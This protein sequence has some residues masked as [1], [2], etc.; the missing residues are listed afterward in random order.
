MGQKIMTEVVEDTLNPIFY[1]ARDFN[2]D[3]HDVASAPPIV[4]SFF[5]ANKG[6]LGQDYREDR[7]VY[8]GRTM[9]NLADCNANDQK[10]REG[11]TFAPENPNTFPQP[12]WYPIYYNND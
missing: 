5:D 2:I 11:M 7:N 9:I 3:Y 10:Y 12:R 8:L 1:C 6:L 4:F